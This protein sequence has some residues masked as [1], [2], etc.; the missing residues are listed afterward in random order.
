MAKKTNKKSA[1]KKPRTTRQPGAPQDADLSSK[2]TSPPPRVD[3]TGSDTSPDV[4]ALRKFVAYAGT[5]EGDEKGEAQ[6]LLD[7]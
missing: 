2:E 7:C 1:K 3:V 6:I 5:L 4:D